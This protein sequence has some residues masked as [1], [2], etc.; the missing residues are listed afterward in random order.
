M[1]K[2]QTFQEFLATTTNKI[3]VVEFVYALI[4]AIIIASFLSLVY[5]KFGKSLSNRRAF[6]QNFILITAITM[7]IIAVV[8]SSLALSL[9]LVGA[10]SIIR[11]RTAIK[12]PEE[13]AYMFFCI[14]VG[15]GLGAGQYLVV[16]V[17]SVIIIS[18]VIL[19]SVVFYKKEQN[20]NL[21]ITISSKN[22][23]D[24]LL[25]S[26]NEVLKKNCSSVNLKRFSEREDFLEADY[27]IEFKDFKKINRLKKDLQGID[28]TFQID[29]LDNSGFF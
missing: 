5:R 13:L 6:A 16:V 18:V 14:A 26:I 7:V 20:Q 28:K 1:N 3:D 4:T 12:E 22:T 25:E 8:K 23:N 27:L 9:G 17:S 24:I 15:L 10:L 29:F 11:F 19:R 2:I 21:L